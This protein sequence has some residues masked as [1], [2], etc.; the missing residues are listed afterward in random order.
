MVIVVLG[1]A[2]SGKTTVG[3]MLADALHCQ[4]LEGD[5]LHSPENIDRM[6][7][8]IPLTDSDRGP[9]LSAIHARMRDFFDRG[10]DL[11]VGCSAL[12]EKYR[13]VLA[14]GMAIRWVYLKASPALI[15]SRLSD[16]KDH[17]MKVDM[18]ESQFDALE[19]PSE[20]IVVDAGEPPTAIVDRVVSQL[21]D[22]T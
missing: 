13:Q 1:V 4:Y 8:G 21:R 9:W 12:N 20:A 22:I 17:F 3:T 2:G 16:R 15:R 11:V 19:A 14:R 10:Q 7:R 5:S 6:T 18:L